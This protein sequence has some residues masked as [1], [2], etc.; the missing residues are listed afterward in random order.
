M[1]RRSLTATLLIVVCGTMAFAGPNSADR[2]RAFAT[3][4]NWTGIWQSA[5]WP[6]NVS[7]RPPGGEAQLRELLQLIRQPPYNADWAARYNIGMKNAA[8][9]AA[10]N[11]TF[12]VCS[13]SFPALMEAPW[14]FEVVVLPEET[15]LIFENGQVRHLY[16]DGRAHPSS[17][18]LWPTPLG[19]S[20]GHWEGDTLVVDTVA[21]LS[22]EPL[23]PRAW[24]SM[25]S[26]RAHF[27]ERLRLLD[28]DDV[29]DQL[30]I[31]DPIALAKPWLLTLNFKR[32][33]EMNRLLPYD[34]TE[35]ERNPVVDGKMIITTP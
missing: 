4:P 1:F 22:S 13:R 30:T 11:A 33:R 8:A 29:E 24:V 32:V 5:A 20:I 9:R 6:L 21:R 34:C 23:A 2:V 12:K 17:D 3:L 18:D 25:L 31:E 16:T 7:G 10:Q 14:M 35:N 15:L 27:T 19:D 26:D 28:K